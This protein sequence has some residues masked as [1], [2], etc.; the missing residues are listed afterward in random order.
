[1]RFLGAVQSGRSGTHLDSRGARVRLSCAVHRVPRSAATWTNSVGSISGARWWERLN[2]RGQ[3]SASNLRTRPWAWAARMFPIMVSHK[4][5]PHVTSA[6]KNS[7]SVGSGQGEA[8]RSPAECVSLSGNGPPGKHG[9]SV[10]ATA[11]EQ[12]HPSA[13]GEV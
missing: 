7:I 9:L 13:Q 11:P 12:T 10:T 4:T 3:G 1:M 5:L 6:H 8:T 2:F